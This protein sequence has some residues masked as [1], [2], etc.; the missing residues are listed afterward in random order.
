MNFWGHTV[1]N[2]TLFSI[3]AIYLS[4]HGYFWEEVVLFWIHSMFHTAIS[5]DI[6]H[7]KSKPAKMLGL[8]GKLTSK[9]K[10]RGITHNPLVWSVLYGG[11]FYYILKTYNYEAWWM[12]GGVL[13]IYSHIIVD[14]LTTG[15]KRATP[16]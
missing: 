1:I 15:V 5:P 13:A 4:S 9:F 3:L 10:H 8:L 14:K 12:T 6:D 2:I 16:W 7:A 11:V